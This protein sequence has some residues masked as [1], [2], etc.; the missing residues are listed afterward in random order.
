MAEAGLKTANLLF[1]LGT[2]ELPP[3]ALRRLSEAL[4]EEFVKG[5]DAAGLEHGEV[6]SYCAP[7]RLAVLIMDCAA[8]RS[9]TVGGALVPRKREGRWERLCHLEGLGDIGACRLCLVEMAQGLRFYFEKRIVYEEKGARK[10]F[11]AAALEPMGLLIEK[12]DALD[13]FTH[14]ALEQVFLAVMEATELKLGKIAQP[15]RLALTGSTVSPG[16]PSTSTSATSPTVSPRSSGHAPTT[17][18]PPTRPSSE[19]P[20]RTARSPGAAAQPGDRHRHGLRRRGRPPAGGDRQVQPADRARRP[21]RHRGGRPPHG[22]RPPGDRCGGRR[23]RRRAPDRR[24]RRMVV[25]RL[26]GRGDHGD[27]DNQFD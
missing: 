14:E 12:L 27:G 19:H 20:T 7:R 15:V 23:L 3:K 9:G 10:L 13:E 18:R 1:E 2:E 6:S 17:A 16:R 26:G 4:T 11:K 21:P 24:P 8:G 25:A 22:T 5:L